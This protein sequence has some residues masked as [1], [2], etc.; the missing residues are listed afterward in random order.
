MRKIISSTRY[1]IRGY[2]KLDPVL[3]KG[4]ALGL[5]IINDMNIDVKI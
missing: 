5:L 3:Q 4:K 2:S 1:I